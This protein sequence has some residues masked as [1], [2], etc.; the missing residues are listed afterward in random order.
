M[1]DVPFWVCR[2][3]HRQ[4][5]AV[6]CQSAFAPTLREAI[7]IARAK[8]VERERVDSDMLHC[9]DA[10]CL[11]VRGRY[12]LDRSAFRRRETTLEISP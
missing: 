5:C 6:F 3:Y 4:T 11:D 12:A 2:F 8:T 7:P 1:Q 9:Y 10:D